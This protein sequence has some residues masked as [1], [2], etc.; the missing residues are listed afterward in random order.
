M[1][2]GLQHQVAARKGHL[3]REREAIGR[4]GSLDNQSEA[5]AASAR[6]NE[7]SGDAGASRQSEL[8]GVFAEHHHAEARR[9]EYPPNQLGQLAITQ[10]GGLAVSRDAHLFQDFARRRER[11]GED[12]LLIAHVRRHGMEIDERQGEILGEGAVVHDNAEHAPAETMPREAAATVGARRAVQ[13]GE[14]GADGVLAVT[15]PE[16]LARRLQAALAARRRV[17]YVNIEVRLGD[18]ERQREMLGWVEKELP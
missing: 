16:D 5:F 10:N 3:L 18:V 9:A 12:S 7:G 11:F 13:A 4:A 15:P 6:A 17:R 8:I 1:E 2:S 14:L